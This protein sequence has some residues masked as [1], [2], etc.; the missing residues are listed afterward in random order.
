MLKQISILVLIFIFNLCAF[1]QTEK[2]NAPIKWERYKVGDKDVSVLFPKL[3]ILIQSSNVCIEQETNKYAAYAEDVVYG[4]N[5]IY[6]SKKDVPNYCQDKRKFDKDSFEGGIKE[7]KSFLKTEKETKFSLNNLEIVKVKGESFTYWLINDFK[8]K[9]WF[10]LWVTTEDEENQTVKSF[11]E[12]VKL[13][14]NTSGIEIGGGS[15]RTLGDAPSIPDEEKSVIKSDKN[16]I[17]P[18][19]IILKPPASYT[20][21]ARQ[22]QVQGTVRVKIVFVANGAIGTI[23]VVNSFP[24]G[25]TE[26]AVAAAKKIVFIPPKRNKINYSVVKIVD[27]SFSL[28]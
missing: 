4:L 3:P 23:I 28:Y 22:A 27:Y 2:Y 7:I 24:Y 18:M 16:E 25:L 15:D 13:E 19:R 6:K 12:S 21:A 10:E 26:Q 17:I 11:V 1:A 5:I 8:N 14:K 9:R 20:D